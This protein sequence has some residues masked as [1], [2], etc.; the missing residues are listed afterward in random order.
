[1][2]ALLG[3]LLLPGCAT[4]YRTP[5]GSS[6]RQAE[7]SLKKGRSTALP[8]E[9]R[10]GHYLDAARQASAAFTVSS[11][12]LEKKGK[13]AHEDEVARHLYNSASAELTVL[14]RANNNI[15]G[16]LLIP[17]PTTGTPYHLRWKDPVKTPAKS[18]VAFEQPGGQGLWSPGYFTSYTPAEKVSRKGIRNWMFYRGYGGPLV[19]IR[20]KTT[21]SGTTELFTHN[22]GMTAAVTAVLDFSENGKRRD[23][24]LSLADPTRKTTDQIAGLQRPLAA[25]FSA[26]LAYYPQR[27]EF[28]TG[29]SAMLYVEKFLATS[30]LYML[31]PYDPERIPVIFVH[32][33]ASTP[34]MWINVINE[35]EADPVLR[36]RFQFWTYW[37][38]TGAPVAYSAMQLRETLQIVDNLYRPKH[39]Y[40][41]VS[42][43]MGGLVSRM[44]AT[45][46]GRVLWDEVFDKKADAL[47]KRVPEENLIKRSLLTKA[48]PNVRRIIFICTPHRGSELALSSLGNLVTRLISMPA[49]FIQGVETTLGGSFDFLTGKTKIPTGI[50]SLSPKSRTLIAINKLPI[51][52][53]HH[54]IMG[55]RGR[56]DTPLS[57]DGIVPYWSSHLDTAESELI[58]P[59]NHSSFELPETIAE[60]RRILRENGLSSAR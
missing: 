46:T 54:S 30:G 60:V 53:P 17:S 8:V 19:G 42:H 33:L 25:N 26:P 24:S 51:Q 47:F 45:T 11:D 59:G 37:Y 10:A 22:V 49:T 15:D 14:L 29:I 23:V 43:S 7:V 1:M 44:Q 50:Q 41:L 9:Q 13:G 52:A 4:T 32:G 55:D 40:L 12:R 27:S 38:P 3:S 35:I 58:V 39:G 56:G 34:Q 21:E 6:L 28:W 57:S 36:S 31:T 5:E 48:D 20:K 16:E 2:A 18:G